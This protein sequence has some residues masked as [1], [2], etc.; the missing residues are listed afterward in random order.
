MKKVFVGEFRMFFLQVVLSVVLGDGS[1]KMEGSFNNAKD[2]SNT[3][4]RKQLIYARKLQ[5]FNTK[6]EL[7]FNSFLVNL[8]LCK[9]C[10]AIVQRFLIT[11]PIRLI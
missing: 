11:G 7:T 8:G 10:D 9:G 4:I 6:R 3:S 5:H 1:Q 2:V